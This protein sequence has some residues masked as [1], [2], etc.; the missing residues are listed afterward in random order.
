MGGAPAVADNMAGGGESSGHE[1]VGPFVVDAD[2]DVGAADEVAEEDGK[3]AE[4]SGDAASANELQLGSWEIFTR[5]IVPA[6]AGSALGKGGILLDLGE[7]EG[8]HV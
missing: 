7:G 8:L 2:G 6:G 3:G 4:E 1:N 5:E